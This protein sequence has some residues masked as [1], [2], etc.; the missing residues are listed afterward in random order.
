MQFD[1]QFHDGRSPF[2]LNGHGDEASRYSTEIS[3]LPA[4]SEDDAPRR[5]TAA[6]AARFMM[7]AAACVDDFLLSVASWVYG[8][9]LAGC[10]DYGNAMYPGFVGAGEPVDQRDPVSG[11]Q[12]EHGNPNQRLSEISPIANDGIRGRAPFLVSRQ[13][14]SSAAALVKTEHIERS[15]RTHAAVAGWSTSIASFL[16]SLRSRI[17]CGRDSRLTIAKL[18]ALDDRRLRDIGISRSDIEHLAGRGDRCE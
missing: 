2:V 16:A 6:A 18:R 10:A 9:A 17:R 14:R 12:S 7:K 15:E 5:S 1:K 8:Q 11:T 4:S 13:T 3:A